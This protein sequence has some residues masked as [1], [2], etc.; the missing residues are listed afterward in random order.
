MRL[1]LIVPT[2]NERGNVT[3]LIQQLTELLAPRIGSDFELIIVDDGSP[4]GTAAAVRAA[5]TQF[6]QLKLIERT[7]ERGLASAVVAGWKSAS[8]DILGVIDADLQHPPEVILDLLKAIE[9]GADL[10]VASRHVPGGGVTDWSLSR[11][12][13]SRAGQLAGILLLPG[14]VRRV[15][16][17]M[18]GYF[19]VRRSAV[20]L[21]A[22]KPL[23]Y[24]ILIEILARASINRI[25]EVGYLFREREKGG[26]KLGWEQYRDYLTH[27]WKLRRRG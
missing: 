26:S 14:V 4:D 7:S 1:S 16:D 20:N 15:S 17:P 22:L 10:A 6:P 9:Q 8:G 25:T 27:L 21:D 23:G 19:L 18:S 5:C 13:V 3:R 24:K 2:Y 11:R 12:I